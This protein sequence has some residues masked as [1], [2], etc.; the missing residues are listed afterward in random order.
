RARR[1]PAP[2][3]RRALKATSAP[4]PRGPGAFYLPSVALP[5]TAPVA[6]PT[7]APT[8]PATT[9]PATAPEAAFCSV[10][11]PQAARVS[12][13]PAAASTRR[14][15]RISV[16]RTCPGTKL[17]RTVWVPRVLR[18]TGLRLVNQQR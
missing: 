16:L 12:A 10:L 7:A 17:P 15:L 8:G 11:W 5:T 1:G 4:G 6:P 13:A 14:V 18:A 3:T 2:V 9:A